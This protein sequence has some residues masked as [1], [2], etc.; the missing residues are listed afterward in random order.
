MGTNTNF[1]DLIIIENGTDF[2]TFFS[3]IREELSGTTFAT[4]NMSVIDE[5]MHYGDRLAY[6]YQEATDFV[7]GVTNTTPTT[8]LFQFGCAE[9]TSYSVSVT[10]PVAFSAQ[11]VVICW[12]SSPDGTQDNEIYRAYLPAHP[13]TTGFSAN[14]ARVMF[15]PASIAKADPAYSILSSHTS[16]SPNTRGFYLNWMALI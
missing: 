12:V 5:Y 3:T 10:F 15:T 7:G 4:N 13:T 8:G 2:A 9:I 1:C 6:E 11:P 16:V 14:I